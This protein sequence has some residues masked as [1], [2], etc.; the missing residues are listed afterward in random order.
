MPLLVWLVLLYQ[1][2]LAAANAAAAQV[3]PLQQQ[4]AGL[5][6]ALEET[7]A[8]LAAREELLGRYQVGQ[9][10]CQGT[11]AGAGI[12]CRYCGLIVGALGP[13]VK[14]STSC[15]ILCIRT[16]LQYA[17]CGRPQPCVCAQ[18]MCC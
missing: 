3:D 7:Q 12:A 4:V 13:Q 1:A 14:R 10:G 8:T 15:D 11:Q 18:V 17:A 6:Q 5:Q 2:E 16:C 9:A